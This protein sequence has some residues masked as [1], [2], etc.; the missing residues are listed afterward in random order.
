MAAI[1]PG[2]TLNG[3]VVDNSIVHGRPIVSVV[4]DT[5]IEGAS[6]VY[7]SAPPGGIP[8][9][10]PVT[11]RVPEK[12]DTLWQIVPYEVPPPPPASGCHTP[13]CLP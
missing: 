13:D 10:T 12:P 7:C 3:T 11:V 8:R 9:G 6:V 5:E 1:Q 2:D 4:L